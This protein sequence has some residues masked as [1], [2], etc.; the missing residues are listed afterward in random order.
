MPPRSYCFVSLARRH[1]KYSPFPSSQLP[2]KTSGDTVHTLSDK[3][4]N[5]GAA[6]VKVRQTHT[7]TLE[8]VKK[9]HKGKGANSGEGERGYTRHTNLKEQQKPVKTFH[10]PIF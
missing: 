9:S 4:A 2:P 10:E 3:T 1:P 5:E 8:S 7:V 6:E